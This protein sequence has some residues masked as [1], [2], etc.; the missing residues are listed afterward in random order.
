MV[1]PINKKI[2]TSSYVLFAGGLALLTLAS[3][4]WLIDIRGYKKWTIHFVYFGMNSM[5]VFVGSGIL[6]RLLGIIRWKDG[7]NGQPVVFYSVCSNRSPKRSPLL[8]PWPSRSSF[9]CC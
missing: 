2:W 4:T 7:E 5:M 1:F 8:L 3:L 6:A 9:I